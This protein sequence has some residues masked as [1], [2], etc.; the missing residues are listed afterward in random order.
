[1]SA[2]LNSIMRLLLC[3]IKQICAYTRAIAN[4]TSVTAH[5]YLHSCITTQV[6]NAHFL[7][8][9]LTISAVQEVADPNLKQKKSE[10][11]LHD[12]YKQLY[13]RRITSVDPPS[14]HRAHHGSQLPLLSFFYLLC[15]CVCACVRACVRALCACVRV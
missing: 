1:M 12:V 6:N 13:I 8:I 10:Q 5:V 4:Y 2:K 15:V 11:S 3:H 7:P 9:L 14:S